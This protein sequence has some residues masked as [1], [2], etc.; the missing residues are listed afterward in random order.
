MGSK[1]HQVDS[2]CI[3]VNRDLSYC[4]DGI[5]K[6]EHA[7]FLCNLAD[8]PDRLNYT[9]FIVSVHYCNKNCLRSDGRFE[10]RKVNQAIFLNRKISYFTTQLFNMFTGIQ[11]RFMFGVDRDDM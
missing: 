8:F 3:Y 1:S 5:R 2:I 6:E 7:M 10:L 9:Y 4:L 11:N